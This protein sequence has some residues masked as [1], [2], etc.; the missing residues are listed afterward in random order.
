MSRLSE[1]DLIL[2]R[3]TLQWK[4]ERRMEDWTE[5]ITAS[6]EDDGD[7][8]FSSGAGRRQDQIRGRFWPVGSRRSELEG[9]I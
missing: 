6:V 7:Q 5:F 9:G 8:G 4:E 1:W 2:I 3:L